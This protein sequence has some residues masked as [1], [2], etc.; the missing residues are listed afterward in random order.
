[1]DAHPS[2]N[3]TLTESAWGRPTP[4]GRAGVS[5]HT[6]TCAPL[7]LS[8]PMSVDRVTGFLLHRSCAHS[9]RF[10]SRHLVA[11]EGGLDGLIDLLIFI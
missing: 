1:M 10:L 6:P 2:V 7:A 8:S 4:S 9:T 3:L 5:H 11:F